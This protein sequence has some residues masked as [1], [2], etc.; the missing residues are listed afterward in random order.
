MEGNKLGPTALEFL[1]KL[2]FF[3]LKHPPLLRRLRLEVLLEG[4]PRLKTTLTSRNPT[5]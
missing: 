4:L 3:D 5:P 1:E 2:L